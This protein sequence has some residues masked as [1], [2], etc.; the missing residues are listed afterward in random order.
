MTASALRQLARRISEWLRQD[1][2]LRVVWGGGITAGFILLFSLDAFEWFELR[3]YDLRYNAFEYLPNTPLNTPVLLLR[4]DEETED[5]LNV[6]ANDITRAMYADA[7]RHLKEA[8]ASLIGFDIIFARPKDPAEDH[9][10]AK[11]I[12]KAGNVVLARYIG[13]KGHRLP[14][15]L[16]RD[17]ALSEALINVELEKDRCLRSMPLL[18]LDLSGDEPVPVLSMSLELTRL[19]LADG[20]AQ[21]LDL[22]RA[23]ALMLGSLTV[24]YP[25]GRMRIRF[26][27]PPGTFPRLPFWRAVTGELDPAAVRGK[28]VLIGPST[29]TLHD[30]YCTPYLQKKAAA[31]KLEQTDEAEKVRGALMD[32]FEIHANAIQTILERRFVARSKDQKGLVPVILLVQGVLGTWLLISKKRGSFV[33]TVFKWAFYVGIG[34]MGLILLW[35]YDYW[36]DIMPMYFLLAA[37]HSAAVS[38]QRLIERKKRRQ[39]ESMFGRYV[40]HQVR[41]FLVRHPEAANPSG[42]KERLTIFFSDVRGFTS[43]S[44]QMEPQEVQ[45]LL[46]EYFTEMTSILFRHG[47]TLD[48]FMGDAIMAFFGNPEPQPD[49]AKRAVL[50]ALEMQEAIARMNRKW[51]AEGRRTIGVGMGINTGDVTV[52]NLGSKDFLDYTVIGDAVNLACR[53]EQNAKAGHILITQ[54]TYDEVKDLVEVERME[55]IKVKGKSEPVPVYRVLGKQ[56]AGA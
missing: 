21:E 14:L 43:M 39:V 24:P 56:R 2:V 4:I 25:D 47:G 40:S 10:F 38:Y 45:R 37:Q 13:E 54:A 46:S 19:Y 18:A 51:A 55:P 16:F 52:G 33:T 3:S 11:A 31:L 48:K 29:P 49:H 44:E 36:L 26:Y 32:G 53:L 27:G 22:S 35:R 6:R 50:M 12:R 42:R 15:Q 20:Q 5:R 41:D 7:V 30:Y 23:D 17:A 9:A 8:G 28:I 34:T 1:A